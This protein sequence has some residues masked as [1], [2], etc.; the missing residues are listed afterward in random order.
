M[1]EIDDLKKSLNAAM[2][3]IA[4]ME[5]AAQ[6]RTPSG[7]DPQQVI[8]DPF[9]AMSRAGLPVDHIT[10]LLVAR[11]MGD[12]ADPGLQ[13][14]AHMGP[15][16]S[17]QHQLQTTLEAVVRRLEAMESGGQKMAMRNE[18]KSTAADKAKYPRL[19]AAY[20]A[21]PELFDSDVAGHKGTAAELAEQLEARLSRS[22]KALGVPDA[23]PASNEAAAIQQDQSQQVKRTPSG[24]V[25]PTPPPPIQQ[26]NPQGVFTQDTAKELKERILKQYA[27]AELE[28]AKLQAQRGL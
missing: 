18:L 26:K 23:Q 6:A 4:A 7:L 19:A 27:P 21:D 20:A 5:S 11:A 10:K 22:A 25:D 24:E 3:R 13:A 28:L 14:L 9:G 12:K 8:A 15:T 17:A 1:S 2:S 16:V